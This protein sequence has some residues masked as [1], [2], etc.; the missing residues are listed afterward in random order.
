MHSEYL[1][2]TEPPVVSES[3]IQIVKATAPAVAA[4]AVAI[5]TRFYKLMFEGDPQVKRF[6]NQAHQHAGSQQRALAGAVCAYAANIDNLGVLGP[7]VELIAQKHCSLGIQ[8][9]HYPI[10]GKHLLAAVKDILGDP[11]TGEVTAA[12]A[13]AYGLLAYIL[14]KREAEIYRAQAQAAGGW[15]GY[16]AFVVDRKVPESDV[17]T[18]F[19][20]KPADHQPLAPFLSGQYITVKADIPGL[21][22]SPRN[23]SLSDE[24]GQ[25]HY[26]ISVKREPASEPGATPGVVSN[27]LHEQVQV[28]DQIQVGPPCGEFTLPTEQEL[29]D[30]EPIVLISGGVGLTPIQSMLKTLASR[31][32]ANPVYFIHGS[33]N[34]S[35]HALAGEVRQAASQIPKLTTHFRYDAPL[36]DDLAN[37]KCDSTGLIDSSLLDQLLPDSRGRFF[38]C[39]PK[40]FMASVVGALRGRQ[41]PEANIHYE[42]FGP[43]ADLS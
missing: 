34:S 7:A 11:V 14:I 27:Y 21:E 17:I 3:S 36:P 30:G 32:V 8:A 18:S 39:G 43:K 15:N 5:T 41:T 20:L 2:S 42:F 38:V 25:D 13:E 33:R 16:R 22:V 24:P 12:W 35:T 6:F 26:R 4:N 23:Y 28:G 19:Y 31:E 37:G 9:E 10:V 1:L 40:P 29:A